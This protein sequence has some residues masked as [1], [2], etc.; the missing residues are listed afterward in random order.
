MTS[1]FNKDVKSVDGCAVVT[2]FILVMILAGAGII[3]L[4]AM[5]FMWAWGIFMV[6]VFG[7]PLLSFQEAFGALTILLIIRF[8]LAP[9]SIKRT[10]AK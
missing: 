9:T 2:G 7:L 10:T 3:A 4:V 6:P 5:A 8:M 1:N